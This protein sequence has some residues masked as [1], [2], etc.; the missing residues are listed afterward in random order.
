M[1]G[2]ARIQDN[3]AAA[4]S[5]NE[6]C[7]GTGGLG[8]AEGAVPRESDGWS[9]KPVHGDSGATRPSKKSR[10]VPGHSVGARLSSAPTLERLDAV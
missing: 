7:A 10:S 4:E 5:L 2:S 8:L 9:E 1:G 3:D 6:A